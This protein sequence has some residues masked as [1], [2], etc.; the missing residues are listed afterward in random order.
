MDATRLWSRTCDQLK[1]VLNEDTFSRWIDILKPV[2]LEADVLTLAVENDFRQMWIMDNY[3][4][5]IKQAIKQAEP[6]TS[7]QLNFCI[8]TS[9]LPLPPPEAAVPASRPRKPRVGA[10]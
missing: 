2:S 9:E 1:T 3:L 6:E 4:P 8:Q 10:F 5:L 7:V